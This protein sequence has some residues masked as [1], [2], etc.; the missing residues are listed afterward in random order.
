MLITFEYQLTQTTKKMKEYFLM[1]GGIDKNGNIYLNGGRLELHSENGIDAIL[2]DSFQSA[3]EKGWKSSKKI[4]EDLDVIYSESEQHLIITEECA[5]RLID[6]YANIKVK[7]YE[8]A[9][10]RANT[11]SVAGW[12]WVLSNCMHDPYDRG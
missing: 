6:K 5:K 9:E 4:Y 7:I 8:S 1:A 12:N 11:A 10:S 2:V 3:T